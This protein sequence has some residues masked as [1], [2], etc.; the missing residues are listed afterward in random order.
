MTTTKPWTPRYVK[1]HTHSAERVKR[2]FP[3]NATNKENDT[4][5]PEEGKKPIITLSHTLV[6]NSKTQWLRENTITDSQLLFIELD[7][8]T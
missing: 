4:N 3:I 2:S 5:N 7:T 6:S 8:N 1:D